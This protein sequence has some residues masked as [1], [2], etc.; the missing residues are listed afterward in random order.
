MTWTILNFK[1]GSFGNFLDDFKLR[2]TFQ[3]WTWLEIDQDN[4]RMKYLDFSSLS[5]DSL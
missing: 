5:F 1:I 4:L 2:R 3:E